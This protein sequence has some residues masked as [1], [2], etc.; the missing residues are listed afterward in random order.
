MT[1]V[2][3]FAAI[4]LLGLAACRVSAPGAPDASCACPAVVVAPAPP[5]PGPLPP[6]KPSRVEPTASSPHVEPLAVCEAKGRLPLDAARDYYDDGAFEKALS[7]AAQA[8]ALLPND[9]LAHTERGNALSALSRF[10]E[11]KHAYARALALDP[12]A[13]D[14]LLGAAHLY[15][16]ALPSTRDNDELGS[17]YAERGFE[18]ARGQK[19]VETA[20]QFARLSAMAFND[21]GQSQDAV[22]RAAWALAKKPGDP[23]AAYERAVGLFELVRLAEAKKAFTSLLD[24]KERGAHAHHRLALILERN[25][26]EKEAQAHFA[27]AAALS[28]EDFPPPVLLPPEEFAVALEKTVQSLPQDM[29]KDLRGVPV[30]MEDLPSE[31]DLTA[32]EPPL[33]PTILGLFRGPPLGEACEPEPGAKPGEPCRS[34]AVYRKNLARAVHTRA[35]LL[36]QI[37]VTLLHEIGHLRGED[38]YELAARG[39]E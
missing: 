29:Q 9:V 10:D 8:S 25:G 12:D 11:A 22:D 14:A 3:L 27:R 36:E 19:D 24:D 17:L 26:G 5:P 34:I 23:E 39:L 4:A 21:V 16:V 32:N 18:L 38:D 35:E 1:R 7:C 15:T 6:L 20:V 37:R 13:L 33:S 31:A 2:R 28:P 30:Q